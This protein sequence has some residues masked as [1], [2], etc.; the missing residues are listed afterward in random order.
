MSKQ[1]NFCKEYKSFD[2]FTNRSDRKHLPDDRPSKYSSSC[3]ECQSLKTKLKFFDI[4]LEEFLELQK[5]HN[6]CCGI[7][8]IHE[9]EARNLRTKHYGLYVDHCHDTGKVRGLLCHNCNLVL[10]QAK[11]DID[12]L[13]KAIDYLNR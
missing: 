4:T 5:S 1:C 7:C 13:K 3:K 9:S 2:H 12:I 10:G 6:D 8:G 11:D